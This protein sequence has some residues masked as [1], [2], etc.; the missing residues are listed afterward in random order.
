LDQEIKDAIALSMKLAQEGQH[1]GRPDAPSPA[2]YFSF[3]TRQLACLKKNWSFREEHEYRL[4]INPMLIK[5]K[6]E[7][8][9]TRSTLV[10]YVSVSIPRRSSVSDTQ[11]SK[12]ILSKLRSDFIDR[13]VIGPSPNKELSSKAVGLFFDQKKMN[14]EIGCSD[15]PYRDW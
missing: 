15:V 11:E 3:I 4:L 7:F 6:I 8:R 1:T 10:P 5:P 13:L 14:V 9:S 12:G 2:V